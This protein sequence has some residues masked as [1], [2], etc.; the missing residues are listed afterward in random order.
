MDVTE[1]LKIKWTNKPADNLDTEDSDCLPAARKKDMRHLS[2]QY[3]SDYLSIKKPPN[4]SFP[5]TKTH[6]HQSWEDSKP[7]SLS[8]GYLFLLL[9]F[10][11]MQPEL[12]HRG[13]KNHWAQELER[14]G[15]DQRAKGSLASREPLLSSVWSLKQEHSPSSW[16]RASFPPVKQDCSLSA[17]EAPGHG[18]AFSSC[19]APAEWT[20]GLC[21]AR[22]AVQGLPHTKL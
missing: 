18:T 3:S 13:W 4:Q 7:T 14:G 16:Q 2:R 10:R 1:T 20:Q 21:A 5:I 11:V 15:R 12:L 22:A 8:A 6:Q 9:G 17:A 19:T